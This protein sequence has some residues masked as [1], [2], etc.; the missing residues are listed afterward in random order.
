MYVY[1]HICM[2]AYMHMYVRVC[3]FCL[4]ICTNLCII[5]VCT[6]IYYTYTYYI[7]A[8]IDMQIHTDVNMYTH[9]FRK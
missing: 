3:F 9:V 4:Y 6:Y 1:I 8:Y 5:E 7:S 2:Y